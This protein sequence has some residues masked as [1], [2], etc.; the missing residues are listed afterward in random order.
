MLKQKKGSLKIGL[1]LLFVYSVVKAKEKLFKNWLKIIIC[2]M[3][4]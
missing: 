4:C 3:C 2:L 1:K